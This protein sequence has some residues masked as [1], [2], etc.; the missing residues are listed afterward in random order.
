MQSNFHSLLALGLA[1]FALPMTSAIGQAFP[2]RN[3]SIV[4][5]FSAG[6]GVDITARLLADKLRNTLGGTVTA[7]LQDPELAKRLREQGGELASMTPQQFK[8]FVK[9]E[10]LPFE[11]I[12]TT[13]QI[14]AQ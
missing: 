11:P 1:L 6:G 13:A 2:S 7:V 12:V 5:P 9:N 8:D 14:V 10:S 3:V 4:V